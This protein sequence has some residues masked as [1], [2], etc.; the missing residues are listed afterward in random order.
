MRVSFFKKKLIY[1]YLISVG[2]GEE[3]TNN[4]G[5]IVKCCK[6]GVKVTFLQWEDMGMF[7][8]VIGSLPVWAGVDRQLL[9]EGLWIKSYFPISRR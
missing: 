7:Y 5:A 2:N 3:G 6:P 8:D 4:A 1:G 9:K